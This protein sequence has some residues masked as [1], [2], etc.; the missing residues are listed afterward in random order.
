MNSPAPT[1]GRCLHCGQFR[2]SQVRPITAGS[3]GARL[4]DILREAK[5]PM[6]LS[7]LVYLTGDSIGSVAGRL[8]RLVQDGFLDRQGK[9]HRYTYTLGPRA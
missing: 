3:M 5:E 8:T 1:A 9:T 4:L 2:R 7:Q 6:N